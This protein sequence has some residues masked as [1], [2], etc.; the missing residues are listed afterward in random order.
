[1]A[2]KVLNSR[3]E[4]NEATAFGAN[5]VEDGV[6]KGRGGNGGGI[7]M[8]G[9]GKSLELCGVELVGNTSGAFGGG[10]FRTS[11][12]GEATTIH[13]S[14]VADNLAKDREDDLPSGAGALYLQGSAVTITDTTVSGNQA[15]SSSG[16]WILGHGPA[17][18]LANLTNV[19]IAGNATWP[20]DPFTERGLGGGLT[21]GD[22]T[23]GELV[24]CTIVDNAAQFASGIARASTL[25]IRNSIIANI[26]DNEY[27]PLNCTGTSYAMP[28]A[29]GQGNIQWPNGLKDD[30]DC[31]PAILREDPLLGELADH[32]GPTLT[33][34]PSDQSPALLG[35]AECPPTDQRGEPR[36]EPCTIG[37]LE[38]PS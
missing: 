36:G 31:T 27:T 5:Y 25:T 7:V 20:R 29:A 21:I 22:N 24:N 3:I 16:V 10:V 18:A 38:V 8:D 26:A 15:R 37:A 13:R 4:G 23:S 30:M 33:I 9:K 6:Q 14:T 19:T 35:G 12:E 34:M 32:G 2:L 11:Y 28:P 17:A 1:M